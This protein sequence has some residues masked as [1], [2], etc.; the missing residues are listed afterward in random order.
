MRN[1]AVTLCAALIMLAGCAQERTPTTQ[2]GQPAADASTTGSLATDPPADVA[3]VVCE[4]GTVSVQDQVVRAQ[5]D[6]VHIVVENPAGAWGIDL[7]HTSWAD[8]TGEGFKLSDTVTPDTS[9]MGPGSVTIACVPTA[10]SSYHDA[11]VPT[12]TLTIVDPAGL[13]VPWE[14]ECGFGEQFRMTL[15]ADEEEDPRSVAG[16]VPGV[17]STD[18]FEPP[19]YP[20]SPRYGPMEFIVLREGQGLARIMGSYRD[21]AWNLL[22]NACPGSGIHR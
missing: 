2:A 19:N 11:G 12:A 1:G 15:A 21:G 18:D 4:K 3:H 22:I 10:R 17:L 13:Y 8:G 16:R 14:L 5:R 9:A 7:H 20:D 6:G